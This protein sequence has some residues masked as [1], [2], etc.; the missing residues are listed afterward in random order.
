MCYPS[1]GV[2]S[3]CELLSVESLL[4]ITN[5]LNYHCN[6]LSTGSHDDT[7]SHDHSTTGSHDHSTSRSRDHS[8]PTPEDLLLLRQR[9]KVMFILFTRVVYCYLCIAICVAI[10]CR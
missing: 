1:S 7:G 5:E 6:L 8:Q 3:T 4:T 2:L 9:K 10:G